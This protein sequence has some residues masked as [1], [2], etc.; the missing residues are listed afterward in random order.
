MDKYF[1]E[2]EKNTQDAFK[3]A[4]A[5][6]KKGL[7]PEK[8]PSIVIAKDM[9]EKV[10]GLISTVAPQLKGKGMTKRIREL[11]KKIWIFRL[12]N[13][14]HNSRRNSKRKIL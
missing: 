7:D 4:S 1:E 11:E 3:I 8:T 6:R 10:E 14:T 2:I 12:E 5:A 9:P 13:L